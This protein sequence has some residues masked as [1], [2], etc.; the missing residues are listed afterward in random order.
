MIDEERLSEILSQ[1]LKLRLIE[2]HVYSPYGPGEHTNAYD[3]MGAIYDLVACNPLY[4]RLV[5]GYWTSAYQTLCR[6]A[7]QSSADRWFL[8]AGCGSLA[9]TASIYADYADRPVVFLDQSVALLRLAKSKLIKLNGEIPDNMVFLHGDVLSLPFKPESFSAILCLNVLH[10]I[11]DVKRALQEM[12]KV[13]MRDGAI[14]L[15][16]L[17][18]NNRL[19]D[20]YLD[21]L[22]NA[23][24]LIPRTAPQVVAFFDELGMPV[25][26]R[27]TG[28]LAFLMCG[29]PG[30]WKP[31]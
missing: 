12:R 24:A 23:G 1:D 28:N 27:V 6:E 29:T 9:F 3:R 19:A 25:R 4:N 22:A 16:T 2:P 21:M 30:G 15:T 14:S 18:R 7:L 10:C 31:F 13:L 11:E 26:C 17:V 8:D 5:W 20:R